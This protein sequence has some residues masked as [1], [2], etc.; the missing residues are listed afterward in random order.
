MF[1][2]Y[3]KIQQRS[4]R[5]LDVN[6][7]KLFLY[8]IFFLK[9]FFWRKPLEFTQLAV[10][11]NTISKKV[12]N[13]VFYKLLK[14]RIITIAKERIVSVLVNLNI[15]IF[16]KKIFYFEIHKTDKLDHKISF[17][18]NKKLLF[19]NESFYNFD[20]LYIKNIFECIINRNFFNPSFTIIDLLKQEHFIDN[21]WCEKNTK[22]FLSSKGLNFFFYSD[23]K[24][25]LLSFLKFFQNYLEKKEKIFIKK[26]S[27]ISLSNYRM[28]AEYRKFDNFQKKIN[29]NLL[30]ICQKKMKKNYKWFN[31]VEP[32]VLTFFRDLKLFLIPNLKSQIYFSYNHGKK[33]KSLVKK[34]KEKFE[35]KYRLKN[36]NGF[37]IIIESN[38][39]IYVYKKKYISD[40]IFLQFSEILY[41]LPNLFVGELTEQSMLNAMSKGLGAVNIINFIKQNLHENCNNI[42][43]QEL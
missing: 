29:V 8:D 13:I 2:K 11:I 21:V 18:A 23:N 22:I 40:S 32:L 9:F 25:I 36:Y 3:S 4:N 24:K 35:G 26:F 17:I 28:Q 39:R 31:F 16:M 37:T 10:F 33:S 19:L 20:S 14:N 42:P 1:V 38:Y 5:Q 15:Q 30:E 12:Y 41:S 34:E 7:N 6:F 43:L 27:T